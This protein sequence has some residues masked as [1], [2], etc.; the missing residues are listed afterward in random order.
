MKLFNI[1]NLAILILTI[2]I[3]VNVF[4]PNMT[5]EAQSIPGTGKVPVADSGVLKAI[6]G[7]DQ[8]T[9]I[10]TLDNAACK[11]A[12]ALITSLREGLGTVCVQALDKL[13][14]GGVNSFLSSLG[15]SSFSII[16][17]SEAEATLNS[18]QSK[19]LTTAY[20]CASGYVSILNSPATAAKISNLKES[21]D[22]ARDE[23]NFTSIRDALGQ[24]VDAMNARAS[25]SW[26][27]V[28]KAIMVKTILKLNQ[29][30]TTSVVNK[31]VQNYKISDY[32]KYGD[33]LAT[34]VYSMKYIND[35]FSGDGETQMM[36]RSVLQSDKLPDKL[37]TVQA[38]AQTQA[39]TY[40]GKSCNVTSDA[41]GEQDLNSYIKCLAAYGSSGANPEFRVQTALDNAQ[42]AK[43]AGQTNAAAEISQSNG[44]VPPRN[45]SGSITLQKQIDDQFDKAT[46]DKLIAESA[47]SK[48]EQA[49]KLGKTTQDQLDKANQAKS[50]AEA[51]YDALKKQTNNPIIDICESIASP[52]QFV[53]S[54]IGDFLKQHL[55]QSSN[56]KS[57]NLPFYANFLSDMATN[58]LTN[59][60]TGGKSNTQLLKEEGALGIS[61]ATA[62]LQES[63]TKGTNPLGLPGGGSTYPQGQ[64][65]IYGYD[66]ADSSSG[67]LT[68]L[69]PGKTYT[70]VV[71]FT[72]LITNKPISI[73]ISAGSTNIARDLTS[74]ELGNERVTFN[75]TATKSPL[76]VNVTLYGANKV[77][78][79]TSSTT[80][81]VTGQVNGA[82]TVLPRGPAIVIR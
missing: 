55:D 24:R 34:Q 41:A 61:A 12:N 43:Q 58:F 81:G 79:A 66:P 59:I 65:S 48:L 69:T 18:A 6:N 19:A 26:K 47:A 23:Q 37:K 21:Q 32:S 60:L 28:L 51:N 5:V 57:D 45:C 11:A 22:V 56:L 29:N 68:N 31:L 76:E 2:A 54:T 1:K 42:A 49:L 78:L 53:S 62:G 73:A 35:H 40:L 82:T 72:Q 16:G 75:Y 9:G 25:A 30:L 13:S 17:G 14:T 8:G 27:D 77:S 38:I 7:C 4:L 3:G 46:N 50:Q 74:S 20:E 67:R 71:D 15:S 63:V 10:G 36:I 33:A 52:A 70:V 64:L 80:L 44:F 39:Q